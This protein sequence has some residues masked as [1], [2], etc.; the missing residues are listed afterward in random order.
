MK[1]DD[2]STVTEVQE[3]WT[4]AGTRLLTNDSKSHAWILPDG[5]EITFAD[6]AKSTDR[7]CSVGAQ[8]HVTALRDAA[9]ETTG[10]KGGRPEYLG[11]TDDQELRA[12][13]WS[14]HWAAESRLAALRQERTVGRRDGLSEA[15]EPLVV[16]AAEM[17]TRADR[18]AFIAHVVNELNAA[19]WRPKPKPSTA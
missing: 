17:R 13:I 1:K 10:R 2:S 18:A 5:E 12:L 15:L 11:G 14:K 16:I 7:K 4:Y 6:S 9:G 8:Y 19:A 3:V